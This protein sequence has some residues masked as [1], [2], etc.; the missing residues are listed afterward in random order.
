MIQGDLFEER[1]RIE[2][3]SLEEIRYKSPE[4]LYDKYQKYYDDRHKEYE[5]ELDAMGRMKQENRIIPPDIYHRV[6]EALEI[7]HYITAQTEIN[8]HQYCLRKQWKGNTSFAEVNRI[9]R[10]YGYVEWFWRKPYMMLNIGKFKYWTMGW[11]LD[12]TVLINRTFIGSCMRA[13]LL[14]L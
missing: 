7:Q 2:E 3:P 9:M 10:N 12:V 1:E 11:P 4:Y 8:P 5:R 6:E 14:R 13:D